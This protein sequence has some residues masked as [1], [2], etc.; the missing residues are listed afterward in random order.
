MVL[1]FNVFKSGKKVHFFTCNMISFTSQILNVFSL[2]SN[3]VIEILECLN[4][5]EQEIVE[6]NIESVVILSPKD[7][8][9]TDENSDLKN[10]GNLE[11]YTLG[12]LQSDAEIVPRSNEENKNKK[13]SKPNTG[14]NG[15]QKWFERNKNTPNLPETLN[16]RIAQLVKH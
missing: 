3:E 7:G 9:V 6:E 14:K 1:V 5:D 8:E 10:E 12:Q 2:P 4:S 13:K 16:A 11:H 15:S